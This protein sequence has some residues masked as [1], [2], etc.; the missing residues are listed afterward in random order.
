MAFFTKD[1]K[2]PRAGPKIPRSLGI[3]CKGYKGPGCLRILGYGIKGSWSLEV[4]AMD[5]VDSMGIKSLRGSKELK[6]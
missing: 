3:L 2:E 4:Y 1:T 5:L 6:I